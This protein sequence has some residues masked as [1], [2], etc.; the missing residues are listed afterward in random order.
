MAPAE[1]VRYSFEALEAWG[2]EHDFSRWAEE[3]P[4]EF[5]HRLADEVGPLDTETRR[6]GTLYAGVLYARGALPPDWRKT[7]EGFWERL[8]AVPV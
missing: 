2:G 4:I 6:L 1:L 7:L 8:A 5:T 3:T